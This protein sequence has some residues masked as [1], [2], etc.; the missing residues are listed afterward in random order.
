MLTAADK[1]KRIG[2]IT[3]STA[4][5]CL[6]L[7]ERLTQIGAWLLIMGHGGESKPPRDPRR[8]SLWEKA[9][10]RGNLL[11]DAI[12]E[13][14]CDELTLQRGVKVIRTP[15]PFRRHPIH[16]WTGDS[17]DALYFPDT[18]HVDANDPYAEL[19]AIGEGKSASMGVFKEYGE[20]L[21]DEM[22]HHTLVQSHFHLAHWPEVNECWVPV[23]GG[24]FRFEFR[25]LIVRRDP[26][27][28]GLMLQDLERWHRDYIVANKM[29]PAEAGDGRYLRKEHPRGNGEAMADT[30]EIR[31]QAFAK[32]LA[33]RDEKE[34]HA[35]AEKAKA[36]LMQILGDAETVKA[37][38]G[39]IS[40]RQPDQTHET[41]WEFACYQLLDWFG[42][43]RKQRNA[44]IARCSEFV[45]NPRRLL[46]TLTKETKKELGI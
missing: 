29:P 5:A 2:K 17:C 23:L 40:Y 43:P 3:S 12:L 19:L 30:P 44:L 45:E 42:V 26:E 18:G 34:A 15:A 1:A 28:E 8:K 9:V 20:E 39:S 31:E 27:F 7:D 24:G 11:E 13:Y 38:W 32:A 4:A 22:P 46:V 10:E 33:S 25:N 14:P 21:T 6:G 36:K 41:D 35:R 16:A 37:S